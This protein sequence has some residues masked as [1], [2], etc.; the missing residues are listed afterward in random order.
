MNFSCEK[1]SW[2]WSGKQFSPLAFSLVNVLWLNENQMRCKTFG[3]EKKEDDSLLMLLT[4]SQSNHSNRNILHTFY[5][6]CIRWNVPRIPKSQNLKFMIQNSKSLDF[7]VKQ[8]QT[9][10]SSHKLRKIV[11]RNQKLSNINEYFVAGFEGAS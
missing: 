4:L 6:K 9:R 1:T 2:I 7:L 11:F 8:M 5:V 3:E 10:I